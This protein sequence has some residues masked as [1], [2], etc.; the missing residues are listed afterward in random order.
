MTQGSSDSLERADEKLLV[1]EKKLFSAKS[2]ESTQR[3]QTGKKL[4]IDRMV[5]CDA[6]KMI[7]REF[8]GFVEII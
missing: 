6:T 1:P 3:V 2:T 4:D 7:I 8:M 5:K